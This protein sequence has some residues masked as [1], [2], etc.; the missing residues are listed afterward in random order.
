[1]PVI[2]INTMTLKLPSL[3]LEFGNER[4]SVGL[5][6]FCLP[7]IKPLLHLELV[8]EHVSVSRLSCNSR[9]SNSYPT[10]FISITKQDRRFTYKLNIERAFVLQLLQWNFNTCYIFCVFVCSL[11]YRAH[12]AHAPYYIYIYILLPYFPRYLLNGMIFGKNS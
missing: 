1:M 12:K 11:I 3:G 7:R 8:S 9:V 2:P 5:S 10:R 6:S 4:S